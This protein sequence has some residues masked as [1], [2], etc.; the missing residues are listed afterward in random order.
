VVFVSYRVLDSTNAFSDDGIVAAGVD[1]MVADHNNYHPSEMA[2][3]NLSLSTNVGFGFALD[4]AIKNAV[5]AGIT[6]VASTG[7]I[8]AGS[9][10][11]DACDISPAHLGSPAQWGYNPSGASIITVGATT[12]TDQFWSGSKACACV[13]IL[14]PGEQIDV[15]V[16]ADSIW[17]E[18]GTSFAAPHVAG[19]A[20]LYLEYLQTPNAPSAVESYIKTMASAGV[21]GGIPSTPAGTPNAFIY[22]GWYSARRRICCVY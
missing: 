18:T 17:H 6:V 19:V 15:P 20:A 4:T 11:L 16:S 12:K 13:D 5:L 10:S 2:V 7:N 21:I 14:A 9:P 1:A 8:N 3:A 22:S